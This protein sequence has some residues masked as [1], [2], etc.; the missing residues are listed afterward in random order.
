MEKKLSFP[1]DE[2]EKLSQ[3]FKENNLQELLIES[4]DFYIKLSKGVSNVLSSGVVLSTVSGGVVQGVQQPQVKSPQPTQVVSSPKKQSVADEFSDETKYHKV[5]SPINGTL[6]RSP[7]P[8]AEPFVKEGEHI[9]SGQTLCIV[10]AMKVMNE[11]KSPVSGKV[12]KIL[13]NNA[14]VVKSGDVIMIIEIG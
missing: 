13:K 9:N 3:I 6:Y 11:I 2:L 4:D 5:K 1:I 7:S 14:E 12:V 8:N 10:E